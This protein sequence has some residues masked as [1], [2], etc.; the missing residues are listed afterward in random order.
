MTLG[1]VHE[2][3]VSGWMLTNE[4]TPPC[5]SKKQFLVVATNLEA[6]AIHHGDSV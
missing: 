1:D 3:S 2:I 4:V 6:Y 5:E